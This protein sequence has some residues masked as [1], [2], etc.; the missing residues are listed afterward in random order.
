MSDT[1][2]AMRLKTL[3]QARGVSTDSISALAAWSVFKEYGREVFG[4]ESVSL[5]FQVGTYDFTGT[6][7]FYF[8]PVCQFEFRDANG[9]HDH[10]EQL[11]LE[12]TCQPTEA[13]SS[14]KATLWS[15]D[16][17]TADEFFDAV[18]AL[19]AFQTAALQSQYTIAV[20][21]EDV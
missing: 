4:P 20:S 1:P 21:H 13:L 17:T 6:P 7:L 12:L 5:L 10:F 11:H 8:D 18:E 16:Y 2:Q 9:E 15:F 3:L 19:S 14:V